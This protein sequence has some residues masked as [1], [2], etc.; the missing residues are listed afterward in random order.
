MNGE[1]IIMVMPHSVVTAA[2]GETAYIRFS[3]YPDGRDMTA[4]RFACQPY[5]GFAVKEQEPTAASDLSWMKIMGRAYDGKS[6][7]T[8]KQIVNFVRALGKC[9]YIDKGDC[10]VTEEVRRLLL[11]EEEYTIIFDVEGSRMSVKVHGGDVPV[12]PG[13]TPQKDATDQYEYAFSGWEPPIAPASHDVT[14]YAEFS[15]AVREY[16]ITW[17]DDDGAVLHVDMI[18]YGN[19]PFYIGVPTKKSDEQ[20]YYVFSEWTPSVSSVTGA[21]TYTAQYNSYP[22]SYSV[23]WVSDGVV[24]KVD[25]VSYGQVPQYSGDTPQKEPSGKEKYTFSHWEP[26]VSAVVGDATYTAVFTAEPN[27]MGLAVVYDNTIPV[28]SSTALSDL[29][30]IVRAVYADGTY[31]EPLQHGSDYGMV[32][33]A[34]NPGV[35]TTDTDN[36]V[37]VSGYGTYEGLSTTFA[38]SVVEKSDDDGLLHLTPDDGVNTSEIGLQNAN[39]LQ[40]ALNRGGTVTLYPGEYP[41]EPLIVTVDSCTLDMNG[42]TL[43]STVEKYSGGGLINLRGNDPVIKN[44][45]LAGIYDEHNV[46]ESQAD[47]SGVIWERESLVS[48]TPSGYSNAVVENMKLHNCWGYAICERGTPFRATWSAKIDDDN[49]DCDTTA[50]NVGGKITAT[51]SGYEYVTRDFSLTDI[52]SAFRQNLQ[53][54]YKRICAQFA[55]YF[56]IISDKKIE[57]T[58]KD[59]DGTVIGTPISE[60]PGMPVEIPEGAETASIK[61]FWNEGNEAWK[62]WYDSD[63]VLH[64]RAIGLWFM[65]DFVGGLTVKDCHT[66]NN[67]SLGMVGAGTGKTTAQNCVSWGNGRIY[68]DETYKDR[69]TAGFIDIE[70]TPSAYVELD[71][72][73]SHDENHFAMLGAYNAKVTNCSGKDVIIYCGWGADISTDADATVTSETGEAVEAGVYPGAGGCGTSSESVTTPVTVTNC[74]MGNFTSGVHAPENVVGTNC[75]IEQ[76]NRG[77]RGENDN[78]N[79]FRTGKNKFFYEFSSANVKIGDVTGIWEAE[80]YI[81]FDGTAMPSCGY[82]FSK[83]ATEVGT[84]LTIQVSCDDGQTRAYPIKT[85]GDC[86]GLHS[87]VAII[88]SYDTDGIANSTFA[89]TFPLP[90]SSVTPKG[91]YENC[92]FDTSEECFIKLPTANNITTGSFTFNKCTIN[93][94][95][96]YLLGTADTTNSYGWHDGFT[97]YVNNSEIEDKTKLCK[98]SKNGAATVTIDGVEQ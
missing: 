6:G 87:N 81:H 98:T 46:D 70:D 50:N 22:M 60:V 97:L 89:T 62:H 55:G 3:N 67:Y 54:P 95:Q 23:K 74:K 1:K 92:T 61:A 69:G 31:T 8:A 17:L 45:E 2:D 29:D 53:P 7:F 14:Y 80:I 96:N 77:T 16:P 84:D 93:N 24:L 20:C 83:L 21:A 71:H 30:V 39:V 68:D 32:I 34:P 12:Y 58:F 63:G 42:S 35:W 85:T 59:T 57:Y 36:T 43:T 88:P 90:Y 11:A 56:R 28:Y 44:G 82:I 72:C 49:M 37:A 9:A 79:G 26:E 25:T 65:D 78:F 52:P 91:K 33:T 5:V 47:E 48:L 19:M 94:S 13:G 27:Y 10:A 76:L 40:E 86:Y 41:L 18:P 38:V 66:Y 4:G 64:Y 15:E 51:D 75:T 73:Y